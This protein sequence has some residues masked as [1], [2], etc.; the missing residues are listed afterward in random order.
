MEL[1]LLYRGK[2]QAAWP[3]ARARGSPFHTLG[4]ADAREKARRCRLQLADGLDPLAERRQAKAAEGGGLSFQE[5][6]ELYI[7]AQEPAWTSKVHADQWRNSLKRDVFPTIGALPV[8]E[9]GKL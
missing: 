3:L 4:L 6:A 1:P 2:R 8:A 9:I 5:V 7:A